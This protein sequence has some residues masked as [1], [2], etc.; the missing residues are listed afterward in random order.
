MC[1]KEMGLSD[2]NLD[3]IFKSGENEGL[4]MLQTFFDHGM[5]KLK[6]KPVKQ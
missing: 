6:V 4:R 3:R 2:A 1:L 5:I